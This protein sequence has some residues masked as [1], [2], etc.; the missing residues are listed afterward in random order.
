VNCRAIVCDAG[1]INGA[2]TGAAGSASGSADGA[3]G[4]NAGFTAAGVSLAG[5]VEIA[6]A[7]ADGVPDA[8]VVATFPDFCSN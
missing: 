5:T 1:G 3:A 8:G 7:S 2:R 6:R 4:V